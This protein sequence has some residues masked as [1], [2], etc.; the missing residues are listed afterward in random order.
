LNLNVT[1]KP[2][3]KH[4]STTKALKPF[5]VS[6]ALDNILEIKKI[7]NSKCSHQEKR[8][9]YSSGILVA[10]ISLSLHSLR[11]V[12]V[13]FTKLDSLRRETFSK[14]N[15]KH[16]SLLEELWSNLRPGVSRQGPSDWS[17]L[18]FQGLDPSTDLRG[19]GLL[20][21]VQLVYF[22]ARGQGAEAQRV[23]VVSHHP[24]RFFPLAATGINVTAFVMELFLETRL[25]RA[26]FDRFE[27]VA[28]L[29]SSS[30]ADGP[31]TDRLVV[32]STCEAVHEIYCAVYREFARLWEERDPRDVM[33]FPDVF[34]EVKRIFRGKLIEL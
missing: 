12:N 29:D 7:S 3:Q 18:G 34:G 26:I 10:N 20:G 30:S 16:V 9:S 5:S 25:H 33:A 22:S 13:T 28:L 19:M 15:P 27:A 4:L 11:L 14:Q 31:S 23:L 6:A 8:P 21:L 24:R 2:K 17:E 1:N 32:D